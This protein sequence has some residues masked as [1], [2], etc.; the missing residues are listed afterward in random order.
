MHIYIV[1]LAFKPVMPNISTVIIL[2]YLYTIYVCVGVCVCVY[3][4]NVICCPFPVEYTITLSLLD[5]AFSSPLLPP[6]PYYSSSTSPPSPPFLPST[7]I[8]P[9]IVDI[10]ELVL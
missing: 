1:A 10:L 6:P 3:Y 7:A 5:H 9:P 2:T 4:V 8:A